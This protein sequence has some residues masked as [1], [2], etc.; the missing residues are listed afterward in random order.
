[1]IDTRCGAWA[2]FLKNPKKYQALGTRPPKGILLEGEP[3]T[4]KTL[5]AKAVAGEAGAGPVHIYFGDTDH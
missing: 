1:M 3:G 2:Q 5:I 4:G